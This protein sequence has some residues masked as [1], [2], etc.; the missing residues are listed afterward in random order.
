[1]RAPLSEIV[2]LALRFE[3]ALAANLLVLIHA[4]NVADDT[5]GAIALRNC[6]NDLFFLG[7]FLKT[8]QIE[9]SLNS[10]CNGANKPIKIS[11]LTCIRSL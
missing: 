6:I 1:M 11:I 7:I 3:D 5:Y 2:V 9:V 4:W 10:F 8:S